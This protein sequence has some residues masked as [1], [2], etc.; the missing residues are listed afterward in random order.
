MNLLKYFPNP[1]YAG[2]QFAFFLSCTNVLSIPNI[3][4]LIQSCSFFRSLQ[5]LH[6]F[7]YIAFFVLLCYLHIKQLKIDGT[8]VFS[9]FNFLISYLIYSLKRKIIVTNIQNKKLIN[10]IQQQI[11]EINNT[12]AIYYKIKLIHKNIKK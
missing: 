11:N 1:V 6:C 10:I 5:C 7:L 2:S 4:W 8:T 3:F 9:F 12:C